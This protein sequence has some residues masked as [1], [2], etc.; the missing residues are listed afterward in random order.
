LRCV[1]SIRTMAGVPE[2][3]LGGVSLSARAAGVV[4][5]GASLSQE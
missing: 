4:Y 2:P 1:G 5:A 3:S